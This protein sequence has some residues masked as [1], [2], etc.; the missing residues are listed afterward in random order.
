MRERL[1]TRLGVQL[2]IPTLTLLTVT[3]FAASFTMAATS[4]PVKPAGMMETMK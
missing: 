2:L 4:R 3:G 1:R